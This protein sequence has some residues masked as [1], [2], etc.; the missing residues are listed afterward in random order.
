M[1]VWHII[2]ETR[3]GRNS[4]LCLWFGPSQVKLYQSMLHLLVLHPKSNFIFEKMFQI[5]CYNSSPKN[6]LKDLDMPVNKYWFN[7]LAVTIIYLLLK[8]VTYMVLKQKLKIHWWRHNMHSLVYF[9]IFH[10]IIISTISYTS[11]LID[12]PVET[13]N[14]WINIFLLF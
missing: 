8:V 12:L 4:A 7:I 14:V 13:R 2:Y 6:V 5:Y 3:H 10:H 1:V 11:V 9:W